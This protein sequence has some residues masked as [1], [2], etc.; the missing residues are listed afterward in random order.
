MTTFFFFGVPTESGMLAGVC[1]GVYM[2]AN[3]SSDWKYSGVGSER[4][5]MVRSMVKGVLSTIP[6]SVGEVV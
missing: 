4:R 5:L 6:A 2:A 3:S 1:S